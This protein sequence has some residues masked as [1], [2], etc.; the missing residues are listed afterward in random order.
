MAQDASLALATFIYAFEGIGVILPLQQDMEEPK[1]LKGLTGVINT[2]MMIVLCLNTGIGFFGYLK[3]GDIIKGS[4]TLN[5]PAVTIYESIKLVFAVAIFLTYPIQYYVPYNILWPW[6]VEK[7]ELDRK[8]GDTWRL[9]AL[10]MLSR[11]VIVCITAGF[12]AAI[13]QL[14]MFISLVGAFAASNLALIFPPLID[15]CVHWNLDN[16]SWAQLQNGNVPNGT[17]A[18]GPVTETKAPN[19]KW[20]LTKD[21]FIFSIGI[22]GFTTGTFVSIQNIITNYDK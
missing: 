17:L 12:A 21:L 7:F 10:D 6:A 18:N 11:T 20:I 16:K 5:L 1:K 9:R 2:A 19:L 3:Y 14:D 15:I 8:F 4:I 22:I 13:P